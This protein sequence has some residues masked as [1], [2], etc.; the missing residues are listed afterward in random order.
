[1]VEVEADF[2][3]TADPLQ[4]DRRAMSDADGFHSSRSLVSGCQDAVAAVDD[5][6]LDDPELVEAFLKKNELVLAELARVV[7][8]RGKVGK[9]I[10]GQELSA[11]HD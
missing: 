7:I 8:R 3:G 11:G 6:W 5:D 1:M 4:S 10:G 9:R 2:I